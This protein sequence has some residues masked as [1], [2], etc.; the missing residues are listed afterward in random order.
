MPKNSIILGSNIQ[1][2]R[3][4][5]RFGNSASHQ[6]V[7]LHKINKNWAPVGC[8]REEKRSQYL[9]SRQYNE[10]NDTLQD[11]IGAEQGSTILCCSGKLA[12]ILVHNTERP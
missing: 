7:L 9:N 10:G 3:Q 2:W 4:L 6:L 12:G 11:C 1:A 5:N 8:L